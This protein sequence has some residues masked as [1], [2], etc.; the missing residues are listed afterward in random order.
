M[1]WY[2]NACE[3]VIDMW[4]EFFQNGSNVEAVNEKRHSARA[5]LM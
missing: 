3:H 2:G 5:L 4:V 1:S